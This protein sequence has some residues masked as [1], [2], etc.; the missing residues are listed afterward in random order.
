MTDRQKV[1]TSR[2]GLEIT[3]LAVGTQCS[4]TGQ[5]RALPAGF[6]FP[7]SEAVWEHFKVGRTECTSM[8]LFSV[9][10]LLT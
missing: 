10:Q 1:F 9:Y 6:F 4:S 5:Y 8:G 7:Y 2:E 3:S